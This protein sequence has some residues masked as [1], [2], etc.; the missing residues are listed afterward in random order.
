V[1][2]SPLY[3]EGIK[4]CVFQAVILEPSEGSAVVV[5]PVG[6][7]ARSASDA[8][9]SSFSLSFRTPRSAFRI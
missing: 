5:G 2:A 6:V 8:A 1:R 3:E 4:G 9:I 7:I